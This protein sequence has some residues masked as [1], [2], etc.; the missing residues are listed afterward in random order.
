MEWLNTSNVSPR[1]LFLLALHEQLVDL[2]DVVYRTLGRESRYYTVV[3]DA[4][5]IPSI[6]HI[7]CHRLVLQP[8][9]FIW[10]CRQPLADAP[11]LA[12]PT[13][14]GYM[15]FNQPVAEPTVRRFWQSPQLRFLAP[16]D[17]YEFIQ[18]ILQWIPGQQ[19]IRAWCRCVHPVEPDFSATSPTLPFTESPHYTDA[20][21]YQDK[22]RD[23]WSEHLLLRLLDFHYD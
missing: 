4:P 14:R 18:A 11:A 23:L 17:S 1:D 9:F 16:M 19:D 22:L 6:N 12:T 21:S 5:E 15:Q 8:H 10:R 2:Q 13:L 3:Y 7:F 20:E